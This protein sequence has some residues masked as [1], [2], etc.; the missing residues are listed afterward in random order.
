MI[1]LIHNIFIGE[2][3]FEEL[4]MKLLGRRDLQREKERNIQ[5]S[6]LTAAQL[7]VGVSAD[8]A[9]TRVQ[10]WLSALH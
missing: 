3:Q 7:G 9:L 4:E 5:R 2:N 8:M 1:W 6:V 10:Q